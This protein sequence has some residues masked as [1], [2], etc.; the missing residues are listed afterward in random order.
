MGMVEGQSDLASELQHMRFRQR[1]VFANDGVQPAAFDKFHGQVGCSVGDPCIEDLD[2]IGVLSEFCGRTALFFK[3]LE[4]LG[5]D[6]ASVEE[7]YRTFP[8]EAFMPGAKYNAGCADSELVT[9]FVRPKYSL[10]A[11]RLG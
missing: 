6:E 8:L 3:T 2:D 11:R 1:A 9:E 10:R 5:S 7:F 4:D